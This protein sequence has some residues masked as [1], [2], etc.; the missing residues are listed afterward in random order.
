M[1]YLSKKYSPE[2]LKQRAFILGSF[3][4]NKINLNTSIYEFADYV[5]QTGWLPTL[6]KVEK[7]D[8]EILEKYKNFISHKEQ[9][10]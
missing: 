5:I 8:K 6:N 10:S 9:V 1:N 7:V 3:A 4:R 2:V